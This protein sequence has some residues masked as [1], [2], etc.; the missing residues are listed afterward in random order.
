MTEKMQMALSTEDGIEGEFGQDQ[1][2]FPL[3]D[4]K[5]RRSRS[6]G[7]LPTQV[8]MDTEGL[9]DGSKRKS[10]KTK[11]N[12]EDSAEEIF[13]VSS[14]ELAQTKVSMEMEEQAEEK[15]KKSRKKKKKREDSVEEIFRVSSEE[16]AGVET[17]QGEE[18][19]L[20]KRAKKK[21]KKKKKRKITEKEVIELMTGG[22]LY[23]IKAS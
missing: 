18:E 1:S 16:L 10:K 22:V 2:S 15:E 23:S 19:S 3:S 17:L 4:R 9:I 11:K 5:P 21:S 7:T 20:W 6:Q 14:E 12:R 13:K 8:S